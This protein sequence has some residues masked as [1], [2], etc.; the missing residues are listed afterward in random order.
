MNSYANL[1]AGRFYHVKI[2]KCYFSHQNLVEEVLS[3]LTFDSDIMQGKLYLI[4]KNVLG[5]IHKCF[6]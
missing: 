6:I 3:P 4:A 2:E 1:G 5:A